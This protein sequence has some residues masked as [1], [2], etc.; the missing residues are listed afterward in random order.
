[1]KQGNEATKQLGNGLTNHNPRVSQGYHATRQQGNEATGQ[2]SNEATRQQGN[3]M[4]FGAPVGVVG[5]LVLLGGPLER[6]LRKMV[7]DRWG[8]QPKGTYLGPTSA[9]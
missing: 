9:R 4:N 6:P 8:P 7:G 3:L 1:M 5:P 2:Q